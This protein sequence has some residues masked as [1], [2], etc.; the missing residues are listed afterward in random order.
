[1]ARRWCFS[2]VG[3]SY[4][5]AERLTFRNHPRFFLLSSAAGLADSFES[6]NPS[7][8]TTQIFPF[9]AHLVKLSFS[10]QRVV[11]FYPPILD[12]LWTAEL[13]DSF[14]LCIVLFV[15]NV[16]L[17]IAARGRKVVFERY[18]EILVGKLPLSSYDNLFPSYGTPSRDLLSK[19][20]GRDSPSCR[21]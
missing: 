4:S 7:P 2:G 21:L 20:P 18:V 8:P 11:R 16:P 13:C 17:R 6:C 19:T 3:S 12:N 1:M 5:P 10:L 15:T 14:V 9:L